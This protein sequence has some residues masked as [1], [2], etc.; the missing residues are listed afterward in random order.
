M[1]INL[2]WRQ[3]DMAGKTEE[4][5]KPVVDTVAA[6]TDHAMGSGTRNILTTMP[7]VREASLKVA[8]SAQRACCRFSPRI[9]NR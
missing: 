2:L 3:S 8:K 1:P 5:A 9:W 7:E 6:A 4:R